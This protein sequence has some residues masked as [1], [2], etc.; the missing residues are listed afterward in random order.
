MAC[1][2]CLSCQLERD[3]RISAE[4]ERDRAWRAYTS[5]SGER[6]ALKIK[7]DSLR[8][9]VSVLQAETERK[10]KTIDNLWRLTVR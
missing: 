3:R 2:R 9:Q 5:A 6:D 7:V 8:L 4:D 1:V 10:T